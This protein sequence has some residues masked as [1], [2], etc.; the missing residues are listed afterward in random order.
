MNISTHHAKSLADLPDNVPGTYSNL[1]APMPIV[2]ISQTVEF[3]PLSQ[4]TKREQLRFENT[5]SNYG[6]PSQVFDRKITALAQ[7]LNCTE[8]EATHILLHNL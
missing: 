5:V 8:A 1:K 3:V 4:L 2:P 6:N 7:I